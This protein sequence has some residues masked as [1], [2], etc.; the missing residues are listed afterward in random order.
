MYTFLHERKSQDSHPDNVLHVKVLQW[1][2]VR[3]LT[4][5]ILQ[6]H[7]LD[8]P[9]QQQ[10]VLHS[11]TAP[12]ILSG[13]EQIFLL[14]RRPKQYHCLY[15][16]QNRLTQQCNCVIATH[17]KTLNQLVCNHYT[18]VHSSIVN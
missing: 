17:V 3:V 12:L 13:E 18:H 7:L 10:P 2:D 9:I 14:A 16:R 15:L 1:R 6:D 8:N 5:V 4:F 11:V